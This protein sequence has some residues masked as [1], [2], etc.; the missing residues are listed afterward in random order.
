LRRV[1]AT[2]R[3]GDA[4]V[5]VDAGW[6]VE[7]RLG[8]VGV[9]AVGAVVVDEE[10]EAVGCLPEVAAGAGL[11]AAVAAVGLPAVMSAAEWSGVV[12]AGLSGW[13]FGVIRRAVVEVD[14]GPG[15]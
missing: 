11:S 2:D 8:V 7:D 3:Q 13:S 4:G 6:G 5:E 12:G 9:E 14:H 15:G 1:R 10:A